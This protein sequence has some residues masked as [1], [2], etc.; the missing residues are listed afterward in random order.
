MLSANSSACL[1]SSSSVQFV[2]SPEKLKKT[3]RVEPCTGEFINDRVTPGLQFFPSGPVVV[4]NKFCEQFSLK[5]GNRGPE[6]GEYESFP[7]IGQR[8]VT[9]KVKDHCLFLVIGIHD[10]FPWYRSHS[11]ALML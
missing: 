3:I 7:A 4:V 10:I 6:C 8:Q 9:G 5:Q 11:T 1:K 2:Q